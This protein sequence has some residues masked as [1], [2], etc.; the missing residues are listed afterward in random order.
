MVSPMT[1]GVLSKNP[2]L[3]P[4]WNVQARWSLL[5]FPVVI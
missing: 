2:L 3:S 1:S 5:T 4:V